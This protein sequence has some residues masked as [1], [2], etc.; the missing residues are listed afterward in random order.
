MDSDLIGSQVNLPGT[1][2]QGY[3]R[4]YGPIEG[5]EGLF[6]GIELVGFIA[7]L[8]GKN[9]GNVGAKR[10]FEVSTPKSGLFISWERLRVANT[11]L[12]ALN[13]DGSIAQSQTGLP[14]PQRA[15]SS[16]PPS[17]DLPKPGQRL[18]RSS[19]PGSRVPSGVKSLPKPAT[20]RSRSVTPKSGGSSSEPGLFDAKTH[21]ISPSIK[22]HRLY[23]QEITE[24][25][26]QVAAKDSALSE[27]ET[28]L[29]DLQT[30]VAELQPLLEQYEMQNA[31]LSRRLDRQKQEFNRARDEW[32][33]S[34][35]IMTKSHQDNEE[36][37]VKQIQDLEGRSQ[38]SERVAELEAELKAVTTRH[39]AELDKL[40]SE[41]EATKSSHSDL[42]QAHDQLME[43]SVANGNADSSKLHEEIASLKQQLNDGSVDDLNAK[44]KSLTKENIAI[45]EAMAEA[46]Q[47][48]LIEQLQK[49]VGKLAKENKLLKED[50]SLGE[51]DYE[52]NKKLAD[53]N[54]ALEKQVLELKEQV[55]THSRELDEVTSA[56]QSLETRLRQ[57]LHRSNQL[58]AEKDTPKDDS[59][60]VARLE[61]KVE[62]LQHQLSMRPSFEDYAD[63]KRKV[64]ELKEQREREAKANRQ[65]IEKLTS[66][67]AEAT[68][69]SAKLESRGVSVALSDDHPA[70]TSSP[71]SAATGD[72]GDADA[73]SLPIYT[74]SQPLDPAAGRQDWCGLC[75]RD[76]HSAINC[77]YENDVF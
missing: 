27:K 40:R 41:L 19:A 52:K 42:Q 9:D 2:G 29:H 58:L 6:A 34:V 44:I 74:P 73:P 60:D 35:D 70:A 24:L 32:R 65:E 76:G 77:P 57:E 59:E 30:T 10:Y 69:K 67:L 62:E 11:H 14:R 8:R 36:Y 72:G 1:R 39:Q 4:Y 18:P 22:D 49:Q 64:D 68:S 54:N 21:R 71:V 23:D 48:T 43:R 75:E 13:A 28:I 3:L 63:A 15:S 7:A 51:S 16:S 17:T 55:A 46:D 26:A 45:K 12:P 53:A 66:Q 38:D 33:E 31:E 5:K 56:K 47:S 20:P 50:K 25:K 61:A 37:Y